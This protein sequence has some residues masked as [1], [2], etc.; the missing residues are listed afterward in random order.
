MDGEMVI[1]GKEGFGIVEIVEPLVHDLDPVREWRDR[2]QRIGKGDLVQAER[3][4]PEHDEWSCF[5][6]LN[7]ALSAENGRAGR[8]KV[9]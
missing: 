9:G 1:I 6:G 8:K 2:F 3:G 4:D 7:N 5:R